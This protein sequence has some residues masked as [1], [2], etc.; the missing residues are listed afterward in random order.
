M[1]ILK[2]K[3]DIPTFLPGVEF[4]TTMGTLAVVI[5]SAGLLVL[6]QRLASTRMIIIILQASD[7]FWKQFFQLV[8]VCTRNRQCTAR[9][10]HQLRVCSQ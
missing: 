3:T 10:N 7:D 4:L 9:I 2:Y 1:F 6:V 8:Y 5:G